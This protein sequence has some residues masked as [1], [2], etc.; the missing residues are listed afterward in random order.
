M[1]TINKLVLLEG[2]EVVLSKEEAIKKLAD[3]LE[4][5][6]F[7]TSCNEFLESVYLRE[8]IAPTTVGYGIGLP[9][10]KGSCVKE[11]VV[12]FMRVKNPILWNIQDD[13]KVKIVF[14]LAVSEEEGKG[15]H[16]DILVELS[17]KILD[18]NFRNR[19]ENSSSIEE[20]VKLINE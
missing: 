19:I 13:E 20:I 16:N 9:H 8:E 11:S 18:S 3:K 15:T 6:G 2:N 17:K 5:A 14:M 7:L 10:G 12:A 1:K 4:E